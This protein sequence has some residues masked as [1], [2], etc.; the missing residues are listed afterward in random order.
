MKG[1]RRT[2]SP[3]GATA[4]IER[5]EAGERPHAPRDRLPRV[6]IWMHYFAA[7]QQELEAMDLDEG[8][9]GSQWP[10]VDCKGW[11]LE[12]EEFAGEIDGRDP[13]EFGRDEPIN[14]DPAD[15]EYDG[16]WTLR[17]NAELVATLTRLDG[18]QIRAYAHRYLLEDWEAE[19]LLDLADLAR[20]AYAEGRH[21]YVWSS[22]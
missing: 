13:S 6:G 9:D 17:I 12:V 15:Q 19:R 3:A 2:V 20:S 4:L 18:E 5:R 22:L 16:P 10:Y 8:P 7:T 14:F 21:L 1:T 11:I